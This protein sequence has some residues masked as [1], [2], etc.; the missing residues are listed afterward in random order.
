MNFYAQGIVSGPNCVLEILPVLT[1]LMSPNF[2]CT[3]GDNKTS[4][5]HR[6]MA[7]QPEG[8]LKSG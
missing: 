8:R 5:V 1:R 4:S 7:A 6:T 3:A 2:S